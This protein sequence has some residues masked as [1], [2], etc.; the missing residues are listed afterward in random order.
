[1]SNALCAIALFI[2]AELYAP[3]EIQSV[4]SARYVSYANT[5]KIKEVVIMSDD[6]QVI[7]KFGI[8]YRRFSLDDCFKNDISQ[9]EVYRTTV[10]EC[11]T[12]HFHDYIQMWYVKKGSYRHHFNGMDFELSQGNLLIIPPMFGHYVDTSKSEDTELLTCEF[13]EDFINGAA[14]AEER[15]TL[16]NLV[17]L[18]PIMLSAKLTK[19]FLNFKGNAAASIEALLTELNEMYIRRDMFFKTQVKASIIK[20]LTLI[21]RE[22]KDISTSDHDALI[23]KYHDAI[24]SVLD[25]MDKN[26]A[27]K[28]YLDE[29]CKTA[30]MS[31]SSF[32]YVFKQITGNTFT[33]YLMYLRVMHARELLDT[34]LKSQVEICGE[35]GFN[36]AVYFHRVF[37]KVTGLSPGQYRNRAKE[38]E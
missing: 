22:Y 34:T 36:D 5:L 18:E 13:T 23:D 26:Y 8:S 25:Y 28:I 33:E 31:P 2:M 21:A 37:K 27:E 35:C 15:D 16:F 12:P 17:Y 11:Q 32:S 4:M 38:Q 30:L 29:I 1:M 24:Q 3:R 9:F 19:P 20:L 7:N 14:D 10:Q 6:F